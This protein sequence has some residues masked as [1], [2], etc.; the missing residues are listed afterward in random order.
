MFR[1]ERGRAV[2]TLIRLTG[3]F[4]VAEEAVQ[5]AFTVALAKWPADGEPPNPGAWIVTTARN[6][7]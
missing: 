1:A 6:R 5:E 7:A 2:A 4:D 3:D